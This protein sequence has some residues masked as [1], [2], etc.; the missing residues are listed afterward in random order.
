[1]SDRTDGAWQAAYEVEE[2]LLTPAVGRKARVVGD[3]VDAK[4]SAHRPEIYLYEDIACRCGWTAEFLALELSG[5]A[6]IE[7]L[8]TVLRGDEEAGS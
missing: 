6:Y 7:H 2:G 3:A 8:A 1:V 5:D 4:L